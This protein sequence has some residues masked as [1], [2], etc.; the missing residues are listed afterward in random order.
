MENPLVGQK[1]KS[2]HPSKMHQTENT[3]STWDEAKPSF[4]EAL[5]N[6]GPALLQDRRT[7][8]RDVGNQKPALEWPNVDPG[9]MN[10][11]HYQGGVPSKSDG[12]PAKGD[13]YESTRGL[14]SSGVNI[15]WNQVKWSTPNCPGFV[16]DSLDVGPIPSQKARRARLKAETCGHRGGKGEKTRSHMP[17]TAFLAPA[18]VCEILCGESILR[19]HSLTLSLSLSL[20]FPLS[21]FSLSLSFSPSLSPSLSIV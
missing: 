14:T 12:S 15:T 7:E 17:S 4:G 13:T 1:L 21:L 11:S 16:C 10:P 3:H 2:Y 5:Q 8:P 19:L 9:L 20:S 6:P 18:V